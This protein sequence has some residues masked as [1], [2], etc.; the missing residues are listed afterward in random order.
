MVNLNRTQKIQELVDFFNSTDYYVVEHF[1]DCS[2]KLLENYLAKNK[3][4]IEDI[5]IIR[6]KISD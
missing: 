1:V 4:K 5:I 3:G 6:K 2:P